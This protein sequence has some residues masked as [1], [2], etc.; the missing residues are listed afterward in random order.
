MIWDLQFITCVFDSI[1]F[2]LHCIH[3]N[4]N[5]RKKREIKKQTGLNKANKQTN[6]HTKSKNKLKN[7]EPQHLYMHVM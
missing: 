2:P 3:Y 4:Y 6:K 5:L 1:Q 7:I